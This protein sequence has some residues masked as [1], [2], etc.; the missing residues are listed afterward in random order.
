MFFLQYPLTK[1]ILCFAIGIA[2]A[3]HAPLSFPIW[4]YAAI[5][6]LLLFSEWRRTRNS[7]KNSKVFVPLLFAL[8]I[9]LGYLNYQWRQ[10]EFQPNHYLQ[11][12]TKPTTPVLLQIKVTERLKSNR[13][14]DRYVVRCVALNGN[15]CTGKFLLQQPLDS[16]SPSWKVDDLL[17]VETIL[18]PLPTPKN[19]GQF[20]YAAYLENQSIYRLLAPVSEKFL[21]HTRG[22]KTLRGMAESFRIFLLKKLSR[23]DITPKERTILQALVLGEKRTLSKPL[24]EAYAG[25]GALHILA[26]SGLHVGILYLFL[27]FLLSPLQRLPFGQQTRAGLLLL[28]LWGFAFITGGTPSVVRAVVMF[29]LFSVATL[30]QRRTNTMIVLFL[31]FFIMLIYQPRYLFSVGFQMSY[32]AVFFIVWGQPILQRWYRP[33]HTITRKIWTLITVTLTAQLGVMPISLYYF[34][35]FPGL[36]FITNLVVLPCIG[37]LLCIGLITVIWS[38]LAEVPTFLSSLCN[39]SFETLNSFI[40]WVAAQEAFIIREISFNEWQILPVYGIIISGLIFAQRYSFRNGMV[41][42]SWIGVSLVGAVILKHHTTTQHEWIV[43]QKYKE[44]LI[45]FR[46]GNQLQYMS[47]DTLSN[48]SLNSLSDYRIARNIKKQQ[49]EPV[50]PYFHVKEQRILIVDSL[51]LYNIH[52]PVDVVILTQSPKLHLDRLIRAL[53]PHT[54]IADGSNYPSYIARWKTTCQENEVYFH[55]TRTQGAYRFP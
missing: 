42:G 51:A 8:F 45:A 48:S 1:P 46:S 54:L 19:P 25:A 21:Q 3:Y 6:A 47:H 44:T 7:F 38:A 37:L 50:Q 33:K 23:S 39:I 27:T 18:R 4:P 53:Q 52:A 49:C 26:V 5:I 36:F 40:T 55:D 20:N 15:A 31:S 41:F 13:F 28:L 32:L 12:K 35:Q 14:Q 11:H 34:H 22:K 9:L 10:P 2:W 24:Q 30:F 29:S 17:L 43:F 16:T